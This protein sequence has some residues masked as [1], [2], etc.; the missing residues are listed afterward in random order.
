MNK[1][2]TKVQRQLELEQESVQ[3]GVQRYRKQI[4]DTPL[5]EMPPGLALMKEALEPLKT[6]IDKLKEKSRGGHRTQSTKKFLRTID[7]Y[8]IAYI[9]SRACLNTIDEAQAIQNIAINLANSLITHHEYVKFKE[10]APK[11]L[12]A[13][14]D[15]LNSRTQNKH[16]RKAVIMRAKRKLDIT[17]TQW[18]T[19]DRVFIGTKLI[20]LFIEATGLARKD[21][22]GY[23]STWM[24]F[25]TE[26]AKKWI[27]E[28]HAQCELLSPEF[29]PMIVEPR[30]WSNPYNGGFLSTESNLQVKLVKSYNKKA[31]KLLE[32]TEMP[33]VYKAINTL[34]KTKWQVNNEILEVMQEAWANDLGLGGLPTDREEPLPPK[35]WGIL[36]DEEWVA[37]K[38]DHPEIVQKWKNEAR[39]VYNRRVKAKSKR[40]QL[41]KR[42]WVAE[43]FKSEEE[44]YFVYV[45]DWRGR[46]YPLQP[47]INPQSDD[48]GKALLQFAE[49][50]PLGKR[51]AYWLKV[52]LANTFGVDKVSFED[53]VKW[54]EENSFE[55]LASAR[56]PFNNRFWEE[57]DDPWSFLSASMEY[58]GYI[59]E[60]V[61][62]VSHLPIAMDGSCNG[63]QNFAGMLKDP[64]AGKAVNLIPSETPQDVYQRVA[65]RANELIKEEAKDPDFKDVDVARG[66][67]N[68]VTRKIAKQPVMT[69]PY[70][71]TQTGMRDQIFNK[72]VELDEKE[73]YLGNHVDNYKASY[74]MAKKI[75][76]SLGD[77]VT[78][79]S[80]VMD[81]M[82]EVIKIANQEKQPIHW[83]TPVGFKPYQYYKKQKTTRVETFWGSVSRRIRLSV[84]EDT[85]ELN[86]R[87]QIAGVSPNFVHSMDAS[88]LMLT[89]NASFDSENIK[90]FAMIH[91]SYGTH[92]CDTDGLHR[93]IRA[94]FID[95]YGNNDVLEQFKNEILEQLDT[96]ELPDAPSKGSLD[97]D[98]IADSLYFFA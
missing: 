26:Q 94:Q 55:I 52:H 95:M 62:F 71:V 53:R 45:L 56:D 93:K 4:Q 42:L 92:A 18:D 29:L 19:I 82:K 14:E 37:Y 41:S 5:T 91:D 72:I 68:K 79:A 32:D 54:T 75:N 44:F 85:E 69:M 78:S 70:G 80:R 83:T 21:Q 40:A 2:K 24:L 89:V 6:A 43:K 98:V 36:T 38:E 48:T 97:L 39:D 17:D 16:H 3:L 27:E 15:D 47:H 84:R 20:E 11:Y 90:N 25:G 49:G 87:K 30:E 61:D 59:N 73:S 35:P 10:E 67:V 66:W 34:Q 50:K 63:L 96:D 60:G 28:H 65:D 88:H 1:S 86:T 74:Y 77:V 46:V 58:K 31:L 57:A 7:S 76:Q 64:V 23:D 81:W 8:E 22:I 12:K 51:G 9:T 33:Q 13:V